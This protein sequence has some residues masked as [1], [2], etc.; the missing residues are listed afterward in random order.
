MTNLNTKFFA[1]TSYPTNAVRHA[2]VWYIVEAKPWATRQVGT[3]IASAL[4]RHSSLRVRLTTTPWALRRTLIHFGSLPTLF[5]RDGLRRVNNS[6]QTIA[7]IFH[8]A[9]S[10]HRQRIQIAAPHLGVLHTTNSLTAHEL[11]ALGIPSSRIHVIP[12]GINLK[13]FPPATTSQRQM[14]RQQLSI[15]A[16]TKVIGS[17]QKDGV[18]WGAGM[19]PKLEKGPDIFVEAVTEL[20]R[21]LPI[22]V[23]LVGPA[24]GYITRELAKR[25]IP[26]T[27]IGHVSPSEL[28][29]YYAVLDAYLISSRVEGGPLS[30]LEAWASSVPVI[31]TAVGMAADHARHNQNALIAP[32]NN[33]TAL[34]E[35]AARLLTDA[36]LA[37][38]LTTRAMTDVQGFAWPRIA[39][40][41]CSELYT[42]LLK[43]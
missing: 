3:A 39:A 10:Q 23:L 7:T 43:S 14:I 27:N 40:R 32:S 42:P 20:S 18:G 4:N 30:L 19:T 33:S 12:L 28:P 21:H 41:Y 36:N 1:A 11:E 25:N 31:T 24:R 38:A 16:H 34:A 8:I 37:K 35:Q 17:F 9:S 5:T 13:Q 15:P 2:D 22:H 26:H 29:A 6:C